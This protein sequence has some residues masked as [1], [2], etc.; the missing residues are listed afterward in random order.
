[1][2]KVITTKMGIEVEVVMVVMM[3]AVIEA[4][5]C[6]LALKLLSNNCENDWKAFSAL[7]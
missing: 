1:M 5:I 2:V 6:F 4:L 3:V 7:S